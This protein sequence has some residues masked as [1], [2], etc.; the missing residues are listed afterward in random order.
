MAKASVKYRFRPGYHA[1][2]K[3]EIAGTELDRITKENDGRLTPKHVVSESRP[4]SAPLHPVFEW[5]DSIAA[6]L[7]REEQARCLIRSTLTIISAGEVETPI[8][9]YL[10]VDPHKEE[11]SEER[12]YVPSGVAM[13]DEE[14]HTYVV[15]D[16]E[17]YLLGAKERFK[18]IKEMAGIFAEIDRYFAAKASK[19]KPAR[20]ISKSEKKPSKQK[21]RSAVAV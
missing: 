18:Q 19:S 20:Q 2:V 9:S 6:E 5:D 1:K 12:F 16:A 8:K 7:H 17:R 4:A 11:G 21:R 14:Y 3:A 13:T 10:N 15:A